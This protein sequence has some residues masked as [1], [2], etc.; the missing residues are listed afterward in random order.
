MKNSKVE[1]LL[2]LCFLVAVLPII[3]M[4]DFTPSNELRYLGIADEALRRHVF[5][6]FSN[7][8]V[9]Y[10]DKPPLYLWMV[11]LCRRLAGSHQMWLLSLFSV[12]PA[13]VIVHTMNR[14]ARGV[15]GVADRAVAQLMTLTSGIFFV[16]AVT[17][18]MDMLM[19]LFI[20]LAL[21]E[22]WTM[23]SQA[24]IPRRSRWLFPVLLFL[25]VF[26]KGPMGLLI[27]L[28]S[29]AA[30]LALTG[31]LRQFFRY[32]GLRTWGVLALLCGLWFAAVWMEGGAAYLDDLVFHQTIGRAFNSFHHKA[33]F[34]YYLISIWYCLAPWSLLVVGAMGVALLRKRWQGGLHLFF[35]VVAVSSLVLLS[36]FSGKLQIYLL[37]AV[38]F[39][40]YSAVMA[41][42]MV[43]RS[44]WAR[45]ALAVPAVAFVLALPALAVA[46]RC[47][48]DYLSKGFLYASAAIL[49][50]SGVATL[51]VL[52]SRG[53]LHRM[54]R[55]VA[56]LGF[57]M[58]LAVFVAS[59]AV[60]SLN[61]HLG[62][63]RLCREAL[64]VARKYG[65]DD[66]RTWRLHRPDNIDVYLHHKVSV[67]ADDSVPPKANHPYLLLTPEC[68]H[69]HAKGPKALTV[70][71]NCIVVEGNVP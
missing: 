21:R 43:E 12:M 48:F 39:F 30:Y 24:A 52:F 11:M 66:F 38:P 35:T 36:C 19:S 34:Y 45:M 60:P 41:L 18:R 9:P 33:P 54:V 5:F 40:T 63:G 57:G 61:S 25:G 3:A 13:L 7:H 56:A 2:C 50:L 64:V 29:T 51:V 10:A 49:S 68:E 53:V 31:R 27:P 42:P 59:W 15:M 8:G 14:W 71:P 58:F 37:P 26:T 4:R 44:R 1:I 6:A 62:Y 46:S 20:V 23:Q 28:V 65:I 47:G 69:S 32:W 70:G 55:A 67:V 17:L 16:A 22:F